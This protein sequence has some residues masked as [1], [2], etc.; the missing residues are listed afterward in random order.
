MKKIFISLLICVIAFT[1]FRKAPVN[2]TAPLPFCAALSAVLKAEPSAFITLKGAY[3]SENTDGTKNY[4]SKVSFAGWPSNRYGT[5]DAGGASIDI[6]SELTTKDKATQLFTDTEKQITDCIEIKGET[7]VAE[8]ID[9]LMIFT[10]NKC[11][12]ALILVTK[13]EE[14]YVMISISRAS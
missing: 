11:D 3:I 5:T 14:S 12:V 13:E 6:K 7:L 1:S 4:A 2:T 8:G 10:K 9:K